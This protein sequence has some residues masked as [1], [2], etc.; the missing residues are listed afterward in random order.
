LGTPGCPRLQGRWLDSPNL[1]LWERPPVFDERR[2]QFAVVFLRSALH[3]WVSFKALYVERRGV[4]EGQLGV[5]RIDYPALVLAVLLEEVCELG[6]G[7]G[8]MRGLERFPRFFSVLKQAGVVDARLT[9]DEVLNLGPIP[10][11]GGFRLVHGVTVAG[12]RSTGENDRAA[13]DSKTPSFTEGVGRAG[14]EPAK[15]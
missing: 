11:L 6:A 1:D 13:V 15:A 5:C 2:E 7:D 12:D 3:L 8:E 4:G 10:A 14:F 9:A